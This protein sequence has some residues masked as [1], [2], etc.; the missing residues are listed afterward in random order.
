MWS[1]NA[2][3][4]TDPLGETA[5]FHMYQ[6]SISLNFLGGLSNPPAEPDDIEFFDL[7]VTNVRSWYCW[8]TFSNCCSISMQENTAKNRRVV[9]THNMGY[10]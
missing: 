1:F 10:L 2:N 3:D 9:L 6:G 4:P 8:L 7:T 5:Q